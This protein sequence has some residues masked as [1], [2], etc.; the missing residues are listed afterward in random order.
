ML[1]AVAGV[2]LAWRNLTAAA[3]VLSWVLSFACFWLF[4]H[5]F[6]VAE[7]VYIDMFVIAAIMCKEKQT[8]VDW[9]VMGLFL[10]AWIFYFGR[11]DQWWPVW[12]ITMTQYLLVGGEALYLWFAR[13]SAKPRAEYPEASEFRAWAGG[14]G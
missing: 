14:Y 7:A 5:V 13:G 11:Y 12:W 4:H 8:P 1:A 9:I 2:A 6:S 3:L 10:P